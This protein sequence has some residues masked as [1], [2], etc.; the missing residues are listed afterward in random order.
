[1]IQGH[2]R[3]RRLDEI[4]KDAAHA[5]IA[6]VR[7]EAIAA[8][9]SSTWTITSPVGSFNKQYLLF[10]EEVARLVQG[11]LVD[12]LETGDAT[13]RRLDWKLS[14]GVATRQ[15]MFLAALPSGKRRDNVEK[16]LHRESLEVSK[17]ARAGVPPPSSDLALEVDQIGLGAVPTP[18]ESARGSQYGD[19]R[20]ESKRDATGTDKH[21]TGA[22]APS[23]KCRK[24]E[25][26]KDATANHASAP[27][28]KRKESPQSAASPP[29]RKAKTS[30]IYEATTANEEI[31]TAPTEQYAD[32]TTSS[33]KRTRKKPVRF[34]MS[35][36][37]RIPTVKRKSG[38]S[39]SK[40]GAALPRT[41][42]QK[43][44]AKDETAKEGAKLPRTGRQ[45]TDAKDETANEG[46][47][48]PRTGPAKTDSKDETVKISLDDWTCLREFHE[49][50][51]TPDAARVREDQINL[52]KQ[53]VKDLLVDPPSRASLK[54]AGPRFKEKRRKDSLVVWHYRAVKG[55]VK[56]FRARRQDYFGTWKRQGPRPNVPD[57]IDASSVCV[58]TI[59]HMQERGDFWWTTELT[60]CVRKCTAL[61]KEHAQIL[62]RMA[63]KH[64]SLGLSLRC[65]T[66]TKEG[67]SACSRQKK[68]SF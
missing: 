58:E 44:D 41:G 13:A 57:A 34:D 12:E 22:A 65:G 30:A 60:K 40:E 19:T 20:R 17:G 45:K 21:R 63:G 37:T 68:T 5:V 51:Q 35:S 32:T 10:P 67:S 48:L 55:A 15:E 27:T 46:A 8:V 24:V 52:D 38:S 66:Q 50:L 54:N 2:W 43:M 61:R 25:K 64:Y 18:L 9:P 4:K 56:E 39:T 49:W 47:A 33:S 36:D 6:C 62:T 1:M 42:R 14:V 23:S 11:G 28:L 3:N 26:E 53:A 31:S 16:A 7:S 29:P 59:A